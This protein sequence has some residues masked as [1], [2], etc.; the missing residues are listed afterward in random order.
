MRRLPGQGKVNRTENNGRHVTCL[1]PRATHDRVQD[2]T[3]TVRHTYGT[4]TAQVQHRH[5]PARVR[6]RLGRLAGGRRLQLP[7]GGRQEACKTARRA[8]SVPRARSPR[9]AGRLIQL[10]PGSP[11]HAAPLAHTNISATRSAAS[12]GNR[13]GHASQA[14]RRSSQAH[15]LPL[16]KRPAS[17]PERYRG[18]LAQVPTPGASYERRRLQEWLIT[19]HSAGDGGSAA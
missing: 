2:G 16:T 12:T 13:A 3:G 9:S 19:W 15:E 17:V 14:A 4:G 6:S 10:Q 8:A 18:G 7:G 1:S 11:N 5:G